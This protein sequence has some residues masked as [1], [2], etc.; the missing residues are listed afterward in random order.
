MC[1]HYKK[2]GASLFFKEKTSKCR[3]IF[4]VP[5][6]PL[7]LDGHSRLRA[8]QQVCLRV[9]FKHFLCTSHL[10]WLP[11]LP[12]SEEWICH[13]EHSYFFS[14]VGMTQVLF[15]A[16]TSFFDWWFLVFCARLPLNG[17]LS[18]SELLCDGLWDS[19]EQHY[20]CTVSCVLDFLDSCCREGCFPEINSR[21]LS[22]HQTC[23]CG[24]RGSVRKYQVSHCLTFSYGLFIPLNSSELGLE[25]LTL[26]SKTA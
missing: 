19:Q 24:H 13:G 3:T 16:F 8:G 10:Y 21:G 22:P 18:P 25:I 17:S 12:V 26:N 2:S 4:S 6:S 9:L 23:F 20:I 15:L 14:L 1:I 11:D 7:M 5:L